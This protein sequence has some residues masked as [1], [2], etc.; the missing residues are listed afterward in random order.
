[1]VIDDAVLTKLE[2]LSM[3]DIDES[4]REQMKEDLG[5]IVNFVDNLSELDV[6]DIEATFS[7]IRG[8][9]PL[10]EDIVVDKK[11][12]ADSVLENS[13]YTEGRYFKVPKI[14]E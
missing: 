2:K 1:M 3:L 5:E 7:T 11:D 9:T 10:R 12:I 14:I 6:S 8:G 4:K 13:P